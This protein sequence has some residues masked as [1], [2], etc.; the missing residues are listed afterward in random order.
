MT[1]KVNNQNRVSRAYQLQN[2]ILETP[3]KYFALF[4]NKL[5]GSF[6]PVPGNNIDYTNNVKGTLVDAKLENADL[7]G[8]GRNLLVNPLGTFEGWELTGLRGVVDA[9]AKGSNYKISFSNNVNGYGPTSPMIPVNTGD[10]YTLWSKLHSDNTQYPNS[11]I[12]Q[13]FAYDSQLNMI[14]EG[15]LTPIE[16]TM[17]G[18]YNSYINSYYPSLTQY[19][20][21]VRSEG[22]ISFRVED[23]RVAYI[24]VK[25][26]FYRAAGTI[27]NP[28]T[29][30]GA[31]LEKGVEPSAWQPAPEDGVPWYKTASTVTYAPI[32]LSAIAHYKSSKISFTTTTPSG[33]T[34]ETEYSLDNNIWHTIKSSDELPF[35]E[36]QSLANKALY[37]RHKLTTTDHSVTPIITKFSYEI[38]GDTS[39]E[40]GLWG[41]VV[42]DSEGYLSEKQAITITKKT[43][44][45][46]AGLQLYGEEDNYPLEYS[47]ELFTEEGSDFYEVKNVKHNGWT[48]A[49][50]FTRVTKL[51]VTI[52]RISKP[53]SPVRLIE[54]KEVLVGHNVDTLLLSSLDKATVIEAI[55]KLTND[56]SH[57]NIKDKSYPPTVQ[58]K[59]IDASPLNTR[60]KSTVRNIHTAMNDAS[61]WVHGRVEIL[62]TDP[63]VDDSLRV[64]ANTIGHGTD[65]KFLA[66]GKGMPLYKTFSLHENKLD[67]TYHPMASK[68][69]REHS[70]GWWGTNLS[71]EEGL[72]PEPDV[73]TL[74]FGDRALQRLVVLGDEV[75]GVFPVDFSIHVYNAFGDLL[76]YKEVLGNTNAEWREELSPVLND[77]SKMV[78]TITRISRPGQVNKLSEFYNVLRE[79]Y[80]NE[81]IVDISLLEE[82]GYVTG[83]IPIGNISAN[84]IDISLS[85]IDRRFD[86]GNRSS[87]LH[88]YIRRNRKVRVWLGAEV[89]KGQIEWHPLG[90]FWST[91]W[92]IPKDDVEARLTARDR[93]ELLRLT[94]FDAS[95]VYYDWSIYDLFEMILVDA[96][97][98][99]DQYVIDPVLKELI[100]PIAWFDIMSHREALEHLAG[101]G[102]IQVYCTKFDQIRVAYNMSVSDNPMFRFDDDI[103]VISTDFP[104]AVAEQTN[105]VEVVAAQWLVKTGEELFKSTEAFSV[106]ANGTVTKRYMF[107]KKPV[108]NV[109]DIIVDNGTVHF[110]VLYA[111]GIEVT[112]INYSS[113]NE[114]ISEV[115]IKGDYL[116]EEGSQIMTASDPS[117]ILE[118]GKIKVTIDHPFIQ[119]QTYAQRLADNILDTFKSSRYDATV[120]NIGNIALHLSDRVSLTDFEGKEMEYVIA[121]QKIDWDGALEA[122]TEVKRLE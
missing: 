119:E 25:L 63:L 45:E 95:E 49:F 58:Q 116:N 69:D 64:T 94:D 99:E 30:L 7:Y 80:T 3:H 79:V 23:S 71:N 57:I 92:D 10:T 55:K 110:Y 108:I 117:S 28:T 17:G 78:L 15:V 44:T 97:L 56:N 27:E 60:D 87:P 107:S 50:P 13:V 112:F 40:V 73:I 59:R 86:L 106:P 85:N 121:R 26:G 46:M 61:R 37:L 31:K 122:V 34:A 32:D 102:I 93:L 111:W 65:P 51:V 66:D 82:T 24:R 74:T 20:D 101:S 76:L 70:P 18:S 38:I 41:A 11:F 118:D 100:V 52:H 29:L 39:P 36:G 115:L 5:D 84:E 96:G 62:Y 54:I 120:T 98:L 105:Y 81:E 103:N 48:L 114:V 6:H 47:L 19:G 88:G 35:E 42:S 22:Y 14:E 4:N 21:G 89:V 104:L 33:T 109:S 83:S 2:D 9:P 1:I 8:E 12:R 68:E 67:G 72:L 43:L 16:N 90:T 113:V 91:E 53:N 77:V 75:L